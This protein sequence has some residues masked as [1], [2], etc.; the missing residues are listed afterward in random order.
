MKEIPIGITLQ[1]LSRFVSQPTNSAVTPDILNLLAWCLPELLRETE[2]ADASE[3]NSTNVSVFLEGFRYYADNPGLTDECIGNFA[4]G[5]THWL[6][7]P[8]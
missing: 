3:I 1:P 7:H 2:R 4:D 5:I 8:L 6:Q